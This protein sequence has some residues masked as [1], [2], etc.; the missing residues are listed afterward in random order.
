MVQSFLLKSGL[1][2][3][4]LQ[5][6]SEHLIDNLLFLMV[7]FIGIWFAYAMA[8]TILPFFFK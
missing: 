7:S 5:M 6:D 3:H 4:L 2:Y 8:K 1:I